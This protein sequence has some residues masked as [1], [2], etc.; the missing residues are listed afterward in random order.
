[1]SRRKL[2]VTKPDTTLANPATADAHETAGVASP[3]NAE[4]FE[5]AS[6]DAGELVTTSAEPDGPADERQNA[7]D[8]PEVADP[9][10]EQRVDE[11]APEEPAPE[12]PPTAPAPE[13]TSA[14]EPTLRAHPA[15]ELFPMLGDEQLTELAA[16]IRARGL[17]E[18]IVSLEVDGEVL[19]LDGRNRYRAS[20]IAGV[21]PRVLAWDGTG[22]SPVGY[23]LAKNIHRRHLSPSQR[24]AIA[25]D[26]LPLLEA[27]AR[28]RQVAAA[29]ATNARA[30][31]ALVEAVPEPSSEPIVRGRSRD[32][33]AAA[34]SVSGRSVGDAKAIAEAAPEVLVEVRSGNLSIPEGRR[35][36]AMPTPEARKEA[37]DRAKGGKKR[38]VSKPTAKPEP[39]VVTPF[40]DVRRLVVELTRALDD[41]PE[42]GR[43]TWWAALRKALTPARK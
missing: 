6:G 25:V 4:A 26:L 37:L 3:V 2:P 13:T 27:E 22:G 17:V 10:L 36:A 38:P 24:A 15:A 30:H 43:P 8:R 42:A 5:P 39:K 20:L 9:E 21:E 28:E 11:S 31:L 14:P 12:A 41:I 32:I 7:G 19:I 18:P 23:V 29:A 34:L 33:A 1:M 16:D 35:I 40:K